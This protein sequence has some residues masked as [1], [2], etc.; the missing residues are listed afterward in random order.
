[1]NIRSICLSVF[2]ACMSLTAVQAQSQQCPII[3][4]PQQVTYADGVF[5]LSAATTYRYSGGKEAREV[6]EYFTNRLQAD[7]GL[8]IKKGGSKTSEVL[9]AIDKTVEGEESYRLYIST[10]RI[11]ACAKTS[12]GLFYAAQSLLQL[13]PA[14]AL[15]T[16]APAATYTI[17]CQRINDAPRFAYRGVMLDP[18]RHFLTVEEVKAQIER[19]AAYKINHLHWHLTEDQGWRVE[20]KKYPLLTEIGAWR[21]EGDGTRYGG[22]YTQDDV[23]E[24]VSFAAKHHM[25]VVPEIEMPGHEMAAIAAYPWLSCK[26]EETTPRIIWGVEDVVLCPGRETTFT[27]LKDVIDEMLPLFPGKLFHIGGDESPRGEWAA[28]DSCQARKK[29][30]GY[31]RESQLQSYL[32][33]RI[34]SYLA[35]HGRRL[36][37]WDEILEGGGLDTSAIVMSWRGEQGGITAARM[38]HQVLMTPSSHGMYFDQ[39]QSSPALEPMAIGGY[40]TLKKVYDYDPVPRVLKDNGKAGYVMGVQANCWS[41]YMLDV[42]TLEYRLYPRALA[43]A[44]V[45]WTQPENKDYADFERRVDN[46]GA[47]RLHYMG[48]TQHI[49]PVEQQGACLNHVAFTDSAV[50]S[51]TTVRPERIVYTLDGS[52]PNEASTTYTTPFVL[53]QTA[54]V[55]CAAILPCGLMSP[56]RTIH[57]EKQQPSATAQTGGLRQ[58]MVLRKWEGFH[59]TPFSLQRHPVSETKHVNGIEA[60]RQQNKRN[61]A[62]RGLADYAAQVDGYVKVPED[63]V[64]EFATNNALLWIDGVL[65]VDNSTLTTPRHCVNTGTR[66]L[67]GGLHKISV[68][69]LGGIYNGWPTYWDDAT[70]KIRPFT[71]DGANKWKTITHDMLFCDEK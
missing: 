19:L 66:A 11:E 58:G 28:C 21:T 37:G 27:F 54:D 48:A 25:E 60:L 68:V 55:R 38:N 49:P 50:V 45:A 35:E 33:E 4:R 65:V 69:F 71:A 31:E 26:G 43:L 59:A 23:R 62:M 46:E 47:R 20:V 61:S 2:M 3:P 29:A 40:S 10:T 67:K 8:T 64:Y 70:V 41:E 14:E 63:G 1:M 22:Y 34:G 18:C 17:P 16:M 56:V 52:M 7:M 5:S 36:V 13:L 51:L 15:G 39:F 44:E 24:V 32:I 12:T 53:K 6:A 57:Y 42:A 30:L 9:F